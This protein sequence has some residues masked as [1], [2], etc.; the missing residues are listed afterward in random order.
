MKLTHLIDKYFDI[1]W[2]KIQQNWSCHFLEI[3]VFLEYS[4]FFYDGSHTWVNLYAT[5][6]S[7]KVC[8]HLTVG[9]NA[10]WENCTWFLDRL[11]RWCHFVF[12]VVQSWFKY[13]FVLLPVTTQTQTSSLSS[14]W[15][16]HHHL[17]NASLDHA[18][19]NSSSV[20]PSVR[21][22][23]D[24][25]LNGSRYRCARHHYHH[26]YTASLDNATANGSSVRPSVH[27]SHSWST[28]KWFK[29]SKYILH[30][31]F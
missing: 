1:K 15:H 20:R 4:F 3:S 8:N 19:A 21:H 22:T 14:L 7:S 5:C 11:Q 16:H 10:T 26:F 31:T 2:W 9:S 25:R 17:Y 23:R 27:L 13:A 30:R 12:D 28:P 24:P 6:E 18:T 29:T